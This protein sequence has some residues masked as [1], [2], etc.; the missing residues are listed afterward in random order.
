VST[1]SLS[2]TPLGFVPHPNLRGFE[3]LDG[4][5]EHLNE[6]QVRF[7]HV[8]AITPRQVAAIAERVRRRMLSWLARSGLLDADD[9]RAMLAWND[10]Y[11]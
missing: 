1:P 8:P 11:R 5:F 3:E 10:G 7:L 4:V 6:G 9:F 2:R